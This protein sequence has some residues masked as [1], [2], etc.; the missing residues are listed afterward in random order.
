MAG[1]KEMDFFGHLEELRT[2]I[3]R[4]LVYIALGMVLAWFIKDE[5][6]EVLRY[7]LEE[8]IRRANLDPNDVHLVGP[9]VQTAFLFAIQ[10]ALF[11]GIVLAFPLVAFEAWKF[12]EPALLPN[13]KKW[14]YLVLPASVTLFAAGAVF[15]YKIAPLGV[16]FL[17]SFNPQLGVEPYLSLKEYFYFVLKLIVIFGLV[18]QLPM[19]IMFLTQVG[20]LNAA[21]LWAKWRHAL[22]VIMV[23]A[24]IV[25]PTTD[26]ATMMLLTGPVM[27]LYMIS[28][29]LAKMIEVRKDRLERE[30]EET[31]A[32]E[33]AAPPS[34]EGEPAHV[35][36]EQPY[37][38][39]HPQVEDRDQPAADD[40]PVDID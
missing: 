26:F 29:G 25:T 27:G 23:L 12:I 38:D 39:A 31:N 19:V 32:G 11:G 36:P 5:L 15:C 24:A 2:R 20:I 10:V 28:I 9:T 8:G 6:V 17:L 40:E 35:P 37:Y 1:E 33:A 22:V 21:W 30:S 34:D 18:F 16:G 4:S 13:E 3:L 7:P 14:A